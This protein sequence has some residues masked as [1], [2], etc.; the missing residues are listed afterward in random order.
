MEH[1]RFRKEYMI[2]FVA[3]IL[4]LCTV[5][6][7]HA[8]SK[9]KG[10]ITISGAF[11]LY[12][13]VVKW[14]EEFKKIHPEV[15][16]DISAGGAGK[17]VTDAL[18]GMADLGMVSR[19][20][21]PE[22]IKKGAFGIAV[23]RDAVIAT[24]SA[25]NPQLNVILARGLKKEAAVQIWI[26]GKYKTW[27]QVTGTNSKIPVRAYTRS[28]ACGAAESW[29]RF[30]GKKQEDL[31]GVGVFGDPGLAMAVQKDPLSI[32][33]NNIAYV[34]D[35]KT[36]QPYPGMK[37]V[38]FDLNNNGKIDPN[39]NFYASQDKL[40]EAIANGIYPSPP[41]RNLYLVSKGKPTKKVVVEFLKWILKDGQ[42]YVHQ[43]GFVNLSNQ[44]LSSEIQKLN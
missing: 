4:L 42:K 13:M 21:Y 12:P 18:T 37:V 10:N 14:A 26:T 9:L 35:A 16:I 19:D 2:R 17:G 3:L 5:Q 32:G 28:D 15:K 23:T 11:A 7:S 22:E 36:R 30:L 43:T 41:A 25:S 33:F 31:L 24:I 38:P 8:Q 20:I 44:N 6:S 40:T 39:E 34:Y 1:L 29:A 27:G